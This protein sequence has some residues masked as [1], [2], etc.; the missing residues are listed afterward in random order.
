MIPRGHC[1]ISEHCLWLEF[2][3]RTLAPGAA[4]SSSTARRRSRLISSSGLRWKVRTSVRV[5][6]TVVIFTQKWNYSNFEKNNENV[7]FSI[8]SVSNGRVVI[9]IV[10]N[11]HCVMIYW[12]TF[13]IFVKK[14]TVRCAKWSVLLNLMLDI[15][16]MCAL[17]VNL[18]TYNFLYLSVTHKIGKYQDNWLVFK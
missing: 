4:S 16:Y 15:I 9:I 7:C 17:G 12:Q 3:F 8:V 1:I 18:N 13:Y 11:N 10:K 2:W 6:H 5:G 14:P